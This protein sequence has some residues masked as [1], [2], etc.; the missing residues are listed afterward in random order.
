[1]SR[2]RRFLVDAGWIAVAA[3]DAG[4]DR[5]EPL[6]LAAALVALGVLPFHR[7]WPVLVFAITLPALAIS[8]SVIATLIA[9]YAVAQQRS[10]RYLL[11]GCGLS[12]AACYVFPGLDLQFDET[13]LMLTVIYA[14]ITPAAPIFLG[15][16]VH[17]QRELTLR[18]A[19]I[20]QAR[21]H[22][23]VLDAQA[24]LAKERTQLAREMHDVV[25]HQVSL[26]AVQAG[27]LSV[28]T[29][30]PAA[31]SAAENVRRLSVDTLD[32]LRHMVNLL[33]ASGSSTTELMPQPTLSDLDRLIAGSGI[34]T[35][36]TGIAPEGIDTAVQ[37]TIYRTIQ[38]ALT[39]VRKHAPGSTAT[40]DIAHDGAELTVTVSNT[41]ATR[42]TL[43]LPSARHGL[44]GLRER[45][46]L[47]GGTVVTDA[48]PDGGFRLRLRLPITGQ[49]S[50]AGR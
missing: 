14:I 47:L 12:A 16:L 48:A 7:R 32:E 33:R 38:E 25:S 8:G 37:R 3:I 20:R 34:E 41:P 44:L 43:A 31:K 39:N 35:R 21:E 24:T 2:A 4:L 15:R 6:M 10:N 46:A 26:I 5:S 40:V 18:L 45:A 11:I 42:P 30:D 9:L 50:R 27:A 19:E 1:M 36:R 28:S 22:E 29:A 17:T 13:D 23:R 49:G